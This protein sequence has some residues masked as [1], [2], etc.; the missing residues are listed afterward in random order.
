[1]F[2]HDSRLTKYIFSAKGNKE[3]E[4][5]RE[6]ISS[7]DVPWEVEMGK[8][9]GS[10]SVGTEWLRKAIHPCNIE[11][12]QAQFPLQKQNAVC[13]FLQMAQQSHQIARLRLALS[14]VPRR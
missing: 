10:Q 4:A 8:G 2:K 3:R 11:K 14:T 1:M 6:V 9:G 13:E 7:E 12:T 5:Y